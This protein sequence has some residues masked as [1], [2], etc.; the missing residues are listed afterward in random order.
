MEVKVKASSLLLLG[1]VES[2][3]I[4]L[5]VVVMPL[6]LKQHVGPHLKPLTNGLEHSSVRGSGSTF[7]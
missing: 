6:E 3:N 4:K 2:L 7:H 5:Q 1:K